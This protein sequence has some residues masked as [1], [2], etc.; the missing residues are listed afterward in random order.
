MPEVKEVMTGKVKLLHPGETVKE[1]AEKMKN[2]DIGFFPVVE[3]DQLK[4]AVTDRDIIIRAIADGHNP[5]ET[6]VS[7]VMTPNVTT[8]YT[9]QDVSDVAELMKK[10]KIRR[11][12]V[13][14]KA[15]NNVAGICSLGDISAHDIAADTLKEVSKPG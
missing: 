4:G 7:D 8:V 9:D 5:N 14:N 2:F 13:L 6:K 1:V 3:N 12:V 15:D 11:I 10:N